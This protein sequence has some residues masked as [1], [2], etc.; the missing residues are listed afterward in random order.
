MNE[1]RLISY[2]S[3]FFA[4]STLFD[5]HQYD[6]YELFVFSYFFFAFVLLVEH[7]KK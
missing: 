6:K 4:G 3:Y 2:N 7:W 5:L 1:M